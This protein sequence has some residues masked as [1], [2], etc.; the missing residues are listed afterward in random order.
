M[1][2]YFYYAVSTTDENGKKWACVAK[3]HGGS[4]LCELCNRPGVDIVVPCHTKKN[5]VWLVN[6]WN[7]KFYANGEETR[8]ECIG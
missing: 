6:L 4:N 8:T 7:A 5:A 2:K 3:A 1:K